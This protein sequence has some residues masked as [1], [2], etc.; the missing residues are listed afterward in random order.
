MSDRALPGCSVLPP[1]PPA[2]NGRHRPAALT[3]ITNK[4]KGKAGERFRVLNAFIDF[5]LSDLD[6]GE[7]VVW[8]ILFRDTRDGV[9]TTSQKSIARRAGISDRAVRKALGR[10]NDKGLVKIVRRGRIGAGASTYRIRALPP[11]RTGTN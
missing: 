7:A 2:T 5:T 9:A 10:L 6:R 11:D 8:L 3:K 4:A 1:M